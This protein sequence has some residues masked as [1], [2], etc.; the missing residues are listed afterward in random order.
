[1]QDVESMLELWIGQVRMRFFK[2]FKD[3][4]S[5]RIVTVDDQIKRFVDNN[6]I[7]GFMYD[8]YAWIHVEKSVMWTG[9]SGK[10]HE[11]Y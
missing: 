6:A 3:G 7:G 8:F 1:M 10:Y 2:D 4:L 9:K 5:F 11:I